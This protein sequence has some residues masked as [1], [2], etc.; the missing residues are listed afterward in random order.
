MAYATS[1]A[2]ELSKRRKQIEMKQAKEKEKAAAISAKDA[3]AQSEVKDDKKGLMTDGAKVKAAILEQNAEFGEAVRHIALPPTPPL[4]PAA[5][6][7]EDQVPAV[8]LSVAQPIVAPVP[9]TYDSPYG[10]TMELE[11]EVPAVPF[12]AYRLVTELVVANA[13]PQRNSP[14]PA[15][16]PQKLTQVASNTVDRTPVKSVTPPPI[17]RLTSLPMPPM[18][19]EDDYD[20]VNEDQVVNR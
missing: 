3:A 7:A 16:T 4:P 6:K 15:L 13:P 9:Q 10:M 19:S 17:T 11:A 5:L 8:V 20:S 14:V 18:I 2:A 12:A 1:L